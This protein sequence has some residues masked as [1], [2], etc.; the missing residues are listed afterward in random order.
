MATWALMGDVETVGVLQDIPRLIAFGSV[1]LP[2]PLGTV[3]AQALTAFEFK[4]NIV[5][6][7]EFVLAEFIV[8]VF[9]AEHFTGHILHAIPE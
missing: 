4:R 7:P 6:G 8:M 3:Q 5:N 9:T 1:L 2:A